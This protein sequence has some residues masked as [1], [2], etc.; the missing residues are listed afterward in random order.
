MV[1]GLL[2]HTRTTAS[3]RLAAHSTAAAPASA[4]CAGTGRN[5][6]NRPTAKARATERRFRCHRFSRREAEPRNCSRGWSRIRCS[7]GKYFWKTLRAMRIA[8]RGAGRG[9]H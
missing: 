6:Q 4:I 3:G 9:A 1:I 5:A 8:R 7:E 2:T